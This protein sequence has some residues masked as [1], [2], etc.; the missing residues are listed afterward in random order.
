MARSATPSPDEAIAGMARI[1]A[2]RQPIGNTAYT[3]VNNASG[4]T[5]KNATVPRKGAQAGD[6]TPPTALRQ[7]GTLNRNGAR[8]GIAVKYA[9]PVSP[10]ASSTQANGR[11]FKSAIDRDRVNFD[12][13]DAGAYAY[14]K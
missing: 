3:T 2:P 6:P 4:D 14:G 5:G 13:G 7:Y 10:E 1:G 8:Y 12:L 11:V 9:A